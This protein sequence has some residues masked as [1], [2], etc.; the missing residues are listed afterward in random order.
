MKFVLKRIITAVSAFLVLVLLSSCKSQ[1]FSHPTVKIETIF[2]DIL[3]ELYPEKAPLSTA[4]FLTNVKENIY[5]KSNF[6]R[7]LKLRTNPRAL[8]NLI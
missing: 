1:H 7:V 3:V 5:K 8:T 2:G 6:Y 4:S